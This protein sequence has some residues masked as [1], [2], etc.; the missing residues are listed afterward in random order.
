MHG[1]PPPQHLFG[2]QVGQIL[3]I[4]AKGGMDF[5]S[6]ILRIRLHPM[7]PMFFSHFIHLKKP[8][9]ASISTCICDPF[10]Y[11]PWGDSYFRFPCGPMLDLRLDLSCRIAAGGLADGLEFGKVSNVKRSAWNAR[12]T[13]S[14]NYAV[15]FTGVCTDL[16][17]NDG[18]DMEGQVGWLYKSCH[19]FW[20][21]PSS[22]GLGVTTG[23]STNSVPV[24]VDLQGSAQ[25]SR[26]RWRCPHHHNVASLRSDTGLCFFHW[27]TLDDVNYSFACFHHEFTSTLMFLHFHEAEAATRLRVVVT[28]A[29]RRWDF[30]H[31]WLMTHFLPGTRRFSQCWILCFWRSLSGAPLILHSICIAVEC[32]RLTILALLY[33]DIL[34]LWHLWRYMCQRDSWQLSFW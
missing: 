8:A 26:L 24:I 5:C 19:H 23:V 32:Y 33:H 18:G 12:K 10:V 13:P 25:F 14:Y 1:W 31:R 27:M 20:R 9:G 7:H 34:P 4:W 16:S 21:Y 3:T 22:W 29:V 17:G 2:H 30:H 28:S 6:T 15:Y 11:W